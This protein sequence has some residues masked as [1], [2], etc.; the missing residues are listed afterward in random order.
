MS[1]L[2]LTP[3]ESF[4]MR[5]YGE[6]TAFRCICRS[7]RPI[8]VN[9]MRITVERADPISTASGKLYRAV[10]ACPYCDMIFNSGL[11]E[12]SEAEALEDIEN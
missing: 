4:C 11:I 2:D 8:A 12:E 10:I 6:L 3:K 7:G 9:D 1:D 5:L